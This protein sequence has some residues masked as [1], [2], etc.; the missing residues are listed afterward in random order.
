MDGSTARTTYVD[1]AVCAECHATEADAWRGSHHDLAM[2]PADASTVLGDFDDT[3]F[4][5]HG[6]T[7]RFF[8]K[9]DGYWVNTEG[10]DGELHDYPISY[11]F[12]VEPLQQ[13]LVEFPGGRLQCLTVAWDTEAERWFT[14]YPDERFPP[15]DAL[16]WTGRYQNWNLMCADC[17]S[18]HLA[19]NYDA[20]S[21][22]YD[23]TWHELNVTCQACHGPGGEHVARARSSGK[24]WAP[25]ADESGLV[26]TLQ[27]DDPV[28]QLEA[29]APCHSRR[30]K[31]TKSAYAARGYHD[32]YAIEAVRAPLYHADGQML[33]EVYVLGSF[34]QSRMHQRGVACSDCHDPHSLDLWVPGDAVCLQCHSVDAPLERFPTLTQKSYAS[35]EHHHH[36]KE[37]EGARCRNC[38]MPKRTYMRID[39]RY[40]HSFPIPRPDLTVLIGTP[41]ACNDCHTDRSAEWASAAVKE[42]TGEDPEPHRAVI[43]AAARAAHPLVA[44]PLAGIAHD[45]EQPALVR[46]T[47]L[48]LLSAYSSAEQVK[49]MAIEDGEPLVRAAALDQLGDLPAELLLER[50]RPLLKDPVRRVRIAAVRALAGAPGT[51]L[52]AQG[53]DAYTRARNELLE[54]YDAE[55][56]APS[57]SLNRGVYLARCG[58][59]TGAVA[60]Y[61][62]ALF[63]DRD[64]L[65][66]VFNLAN[67][68]STTDRAAEARELLQAAIGRCPGEGEL[69]YSLGLLLAQMDDLEGT[70]GALRTAT[71]LLSTRARVHYNYGLVSQQLGRPAEA[72]AAL[73]R[74]AALEPENPDF[75]Y[76]LAT[77]YL[78]ESR[79]DAALDWAGRLAALVPDAPG[80]QELLEE[81]ERR[82]AAVR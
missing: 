73:G 35:P 56:D 49:L 10:P 13:Y 7:T 19:K 62:R 4:E 72:E 67:L 59:S 30:R 36:E 11:T 43:F 66:A 20:A 5:V 9:D 77:F 6:L 81:I 12:G 14:L 33:E 47:A 25:E 16:H 63:L 34:L 45:P 29:C 64:F 28:P 46:A 68:L 51:A 71:E 44:S 39:E 75:A 27:R 54:S 61:R 57:A 31:L 69:H 50:V 23:T 42:W 40:D 22:S 74:A 65:P 21:D 15:N 37:S 24:G 76:A 2:Q 60:A 1:S 70:A 79:F 55:A 18:T 48:D 17:H 58:D 32:D 3:C 52:E 53:D 78:A 26:V 8:Q 41:N 82:R 38:H 80:P